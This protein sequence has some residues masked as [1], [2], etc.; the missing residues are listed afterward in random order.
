MEKIVGRHGH[1]E[2]DYSIG[3]DDGSKI[4][5]QFSCIQHANWS[6]TEVESNYMDIEASSEQVVV[7]IFA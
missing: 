3:D 6:K 7:D 1:N 5:D 2:T 4:G